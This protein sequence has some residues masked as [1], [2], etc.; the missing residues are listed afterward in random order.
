MEEVDDE[1]N[2]PKNI[3]PTKKSRILELSDGSDDEEEDGPALIAVSDDSD[4][5]EN[6]DIPEELEESAETQLGQLLH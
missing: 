3:P 2:H 5:N 4:E 1:D 6:E